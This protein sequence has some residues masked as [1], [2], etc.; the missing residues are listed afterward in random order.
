MT[1][2]KSGIRILRLGL[3]AIILLFIGY[4]VTMIRAVTTCFAGLILLVAIVTLFEYFSKEK[5]SN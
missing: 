5:L 3:I 2:R 1:N 4:F